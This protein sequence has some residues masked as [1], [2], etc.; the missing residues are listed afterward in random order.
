MRFKDKVAIVTGSNTGIG[1]AIALRLAAE[2]ARVIINGRNVEKGEAVAAEIARA[3]GVA[4]F[5]RADMGLEDDVRQ[6]VDRT[7]AVYGGVDILINN[8]AAIDAI[9]K[10][11]RA[12]ADLSSEAFDRI[13][14]VGVYGTFWATK[15]VLP[16]MIERGGG[17]VVNIS[18]NGGFSGVPDVL[19]Y[20]CSKSALHGFS[21]SVA[22]DYGTKGIRCNCVS[23]GYIRDGAVGSAMFDDP[24]TG[25]IFAGLVSTG[26]VGAPE[27]VAGFLAYLCSDEGWYV[28]GQL[29]HF[30]GGS[31]ARLPAPAGLSTVP[32]GLS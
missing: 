30:D 21:T 2:G 23:L 28:T 18:S 24:V 11:D 19:G 26:R 7:V 12:C 22:L 8:A 14:K 27:D 32:E 5:V 20:A 31:G 16:L 25:P 1:R 4:A 9:Q 17:S 10:G 15:F 29:I 13:M 3:G 6:L